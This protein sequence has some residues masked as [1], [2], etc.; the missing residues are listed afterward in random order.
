[1]ISLFL[2]GLVLTLALIYRGP[3]AVNVMERFH[4]EGDVDLDILTQRR[5][6]L[7][8]MGL[9]QFLESPLVGVGWKNSIDVHNSFIYYLVTLGIIGFSLFLFIYL[10]IIRICWK[11]L[12]RD[13]LTYGNYLNLSFLAGF[14]GILTIMM[15]LGIYYVYHYLFLYSGLVLK[16]N[17][18]EDS[19]GQGYDLGGDG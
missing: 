2:L 1:M 8:K 12:Q 7:W 17:K 19:P 5:Y 14:L 11:H 18:L 9:S 15:S 10:K 3:F 13:R 6:R 4:Y 16:Y